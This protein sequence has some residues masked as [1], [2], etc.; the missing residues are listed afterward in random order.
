MVDE[1]TELT[2]KVRVMN[3]AFMLTA[4][5]QVTVI[6]GSVTSISLILLR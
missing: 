1:I 4:K 3:M 5:I 6:N 2:I